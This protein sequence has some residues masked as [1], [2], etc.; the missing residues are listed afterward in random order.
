MYS[1]EYFRQDKSG[2]NVKLPFKWMPLESLQE[3]LFS[4]KSD[5]VS[6]TLVPTSTS[7][8]TVCTIIYDGFI[9]QDYLYIADIQLNSVAAIARQLIQGLVAVSPS[10]CR[11]YTYIRQS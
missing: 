6:C 4:Q 3:G 10:P 5:V 8:T 7:W 1:S 11:Q 2:G 9:V